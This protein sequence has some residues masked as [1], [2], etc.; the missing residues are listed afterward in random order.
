[1][2]NILNIHARQIL[3]SRG[4]PTVEVDII[5]KNNI[6]GRASVPSGASVGSYEAIEFRDGDKAYMGKGVLK[7]VNNI[8][9][10]ITPKLIGISV[11]NQYLIDNIMIDLD[12]TSNKNKL[13][14]NAILP[15]SLAVAKAAANELN[16]PLFQ[17][18]GGLN[19]NTLP[20]PMIN[21][22]N[23]GVHSDAGIPFQEF[24]IIP[25]QSKSFSH[26]MQIAV[27]IFYTLKNIL[28]SKKISIGL[29]DEGGFSPNCL[30][31]IEDVLNIMKLAVEESGYNLGSDIKFALD[32][33]ASEFYNNKIYDYSKFNSTNNHKFSFK[34]QAEYLD[35]LSNKY[36]IISIED[37]MDQNDWEGWQYL[38]KLIG[39]RVQ[40]VGDDLFVTNVNK[41]Y[42]GIQNSVANSIL[43]KVNQI[44][45]LSETFQTI[46]MAHD[47]G[48]TTII[49]HR[50]GET[51]DYTISDLSVGLNC[52]QIKTGSV[53]RSERMSKYNQL[54]RI[55][56]KLGNNSNYANFFSC[57]IK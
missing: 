15:I 28:L 13:G 20:I 50:S 45:T 42:K 57:N 21:I 47:A 35:E 38:T 1:M 29:G 33:A 49:S 30:G 8:N 53:S 27:E 18:I 17:Y 44:G 37:G 54:I 52:R 19:A 14:S 32:C 41:L 10:I 5:T 22:I 4:I 3:D 2:S 39:H 31:D 12:G 40:L 25:I 56:E 6:L 9:Q 36:S 51:E 46:K 48:Y 34:E 26:A 23:G 55:E 7:A 11:F 24:M 43:I 16:I